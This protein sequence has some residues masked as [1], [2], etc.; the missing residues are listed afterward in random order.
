MLVP[1][2]LLCKAL[3]YKLDCPGKALVAVIDGGSI[4]GSD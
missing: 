3:L 4:G 2:V 1:T